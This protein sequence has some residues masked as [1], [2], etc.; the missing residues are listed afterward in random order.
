MKEID[1][2]KHLIRIQPVSFPDGLPLFEDDLVNFRLLPNGDF[3]RRGSSPFRPRKPIDL[4]EFK[5]ID[6]PCVSEDKVPCVSLV[7]SA[8]VIADAGDDAHYL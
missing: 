2:I 1:N 4:T 8:Y 7:F 5:I 6:H 3:V